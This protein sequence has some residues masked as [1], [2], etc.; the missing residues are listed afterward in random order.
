MRLSALYAV[1]FPPL[2]YLAK[3]NKLPASFS[4]SHHIR[5]F[6]WH[7]INDN[8]KQISQPKGN[9]LFAERPV[10]IPSVW[11]EYDLEKKSKEAKRNTH[12]L[13]MMLKF[14][15]KCKESC[16]QLHKKYFM[17]D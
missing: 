16:L 2:L 5:I 3:T 17:D 12:H 13:K 10:N 14:I 6:S 1:F 11:M 7:E 8:N 4:S 9:G 15:L